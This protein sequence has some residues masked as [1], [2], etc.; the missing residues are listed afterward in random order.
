MLF[1]TYIIMIDTGGVIIDLS[2]LFGGC[3]CI[4]TIYYTFGSVFFKV[5]FGQK[6]KRNGFVL[7][8]CFLQT[9]QERGERNQPPEPSLRGLDYHLKA[10]NALR[11]EAHDKRLFSLPRCHGCCSIKSSRLLISVSLSSMGPQWIPLSE[12]TSACGNSVQSMA[13]IPLISFL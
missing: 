7:F 4:V 13:L 8:I 1:K 2:Y 3:F 12:T 6:H 11:A 5:F 10:Q 9:K